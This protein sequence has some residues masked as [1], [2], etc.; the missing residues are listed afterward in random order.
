MHRLF[1]ALRPSLALRTLCREAMAGGPAGWAW[2]EDSQL[3]MTLRYI[4]EVERPVAEDVAHALS[5]LRSPP[6]QMGI[7]GVGWFDQGPRGALFA[8]AVPKEPLAAL[9]RKVDHA[10]AALGLKPEGRSYLPHVTL[11]RRRRGADDPASW[12]EA[13]AG[14]AGP[15]EAVDHFILYESHLGRDGAMY[16]PVARYPL[17]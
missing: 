11:A 4:G 10:I 3:H 12:L 15:P 7:D 17:G 5:S 13:N 9:H 2:Q 1:I 6:L 8:R 14:L 16:E